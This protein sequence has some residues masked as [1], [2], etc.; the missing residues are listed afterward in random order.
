VDQSGKPIA[1]VDFKGYGRRNL[2]V[3]ELIVGI[4]T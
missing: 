2:P 4:L 3:D 1:H